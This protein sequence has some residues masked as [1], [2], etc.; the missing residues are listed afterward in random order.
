[1]AVAL[2]IDSG[3]A[4]QVLRIEIEKEKRSFDDDMQGSN[5]KIRFNEPLTFMHMITSFIVF[6]VGLIL[7]ALTL[8]CELIHYKS[9][10]R[11][12]IITNDGT[13]INHIET[14]TMKMI[15]IDG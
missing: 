2:W 7:S 3:I 12:V 14:D 15:D 11:P 8:C 6:G 1:M 13:E 9:T 4:D 5:L 10:D